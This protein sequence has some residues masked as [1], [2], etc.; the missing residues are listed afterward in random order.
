[1]ELKCK[2]ANNEIVAFHHSGMK[3]VDGGLKADLPM[4]RLAEL[5]NINAFI[6]SQTNPWVVPFLTES[7]GGGSWGHSLKF[8]FYRMIKRLTIMEFRHRVR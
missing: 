5:F 1:M 7:D 2:N 8:R 3:F 4:E 6:V